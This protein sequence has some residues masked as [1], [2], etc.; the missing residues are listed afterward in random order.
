MAIAYLFLLLSGSAILYY[1]LAVYAAIE[2]FSQSQKSCPADDF[3]FQPPITILKPIC[4]VDSH[5]YQNLVSF[6]QQT[7]P[8][9]QIIF[10]VQSELD[11][12]IT[13]IQQLI[14][15][16]PQLDIQYIASH[17]I[18][19][20]NLKVNNLAS[21]ITLAKYDLLLLADSDVWVG[22]DYLHRVV[23]PMSDPAV[24]VVTCLYRSQTHGWIA[25]FEALGISTDF[26]PGVL[27]AR[28]LEGMAFALGA[29]ILIRA[30]VLQ[31]I[32][33]FPAIVDYLEDDLQ[34]GHLPAQAG[35]QVILS[36]Y[37]VDHI[38]TTE[39]LTD[40]LH[41]QTR[42]ARGIRFARPNGYL[43]LIFTYGTIFSLLFLLIQGGGLGW[44]VLILTWTIR[45]AMA[46]L[47][48]VKYLQ[49][50]VAQQLLWLVPLRDLMSFAFWCYSFLG[51]TIEWR[52]RKL[53][54]VKGGKL[55]DIKL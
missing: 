10:G 13:V 40:L 14:Q 32:G 19:G 18:I 15:D 33:G 54:L 28:K 1:G 49:D 47:I 16:F 55:V 44:G 52:G 43:G 12:S 9:Y 6:C 35:H 53:R 11:P 29:T 51:N 48:G 31:A 3:A 4:G 5:S 24:G 20:T 50:P 7:Y 23:Q 2:F 27:V 34:L 25:A 21:A 17:Q 36:D 22:P 8:N 41:H 39:T 30:S 46:W 45:Y 38:M 42:W 37:V 26:L